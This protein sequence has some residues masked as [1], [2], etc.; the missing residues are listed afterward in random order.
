MNTIMD[1]S[2]RTG[3]GALT[4]GSHPVAPVG[5][6]PSIPACTTELLE[7]IQRLQVALDGLVERVALFLVGT[8]PNEAI[9]SSPTPASPHA[10]IL[11]GAAGRIL[12]VAL[13]IEALTHGFD[14]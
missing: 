5:P 4:G 3:G 13:R 11:H 1:H 6:A 12:R 14:L 2:Q 8:L 9:P 10:Q 7:Q